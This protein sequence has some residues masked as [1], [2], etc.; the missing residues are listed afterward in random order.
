VNDEIY[1]DDNDDKINEDFQVQN[2]YYS[3]NIKRCYLKKKVGD[4]YSS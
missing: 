1:E 4:D 2:S 3:I